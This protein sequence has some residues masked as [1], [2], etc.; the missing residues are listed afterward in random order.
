LDN[1]SIG[2]EIIKEMIEAIIRPISTSVH[3]QFENGFWNWFDEFVQFKM[4]SE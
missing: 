3:E 1:I 2:K 4:K